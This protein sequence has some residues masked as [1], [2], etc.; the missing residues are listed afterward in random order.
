MAQELSQLK[1]LIVDDE[2]HIRKIVKAVLNSMGIRD[3][4]EA[5]NGKDAFELLRIPK[6]GPGE[7]RRFDFV[8]CD[9]MMP[10]MTGIELLEKVR[11]E[12]AF[13]TLPFLMLTAEAENDKVLTAIG[14]GVNDYCVKPF[15]AQ[16]LEEKIRR[17]VSKI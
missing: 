7:K 12:R 9:W 15:T 16:T 2:F 3:V 13:Q 8:V 11:S 1:V 6:A 5:S 17:L 10:T 14:H 4:T